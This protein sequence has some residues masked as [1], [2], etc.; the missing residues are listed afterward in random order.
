MVDRIEEHIQEEEKRVEFGKEDRTEEEDIKQ[1]SEE[2]V[3]AEDETK[4]AEAEVEDREG[5]SSVDSSDQ[6]YSPT[7]HVTSKVNDTVDESDDEVMYTPSGRPKR[8]TG[9]YTFKGKQRSSEN[10]DPEYK[11]SRQNPWKKKRGIM[12]KIHIKRGKKRGRP[13]SNPVPDASSF[14]AEAL[15]THIGGGLDLTPYYIILDTSTGD[16]DRRP[17]QCKFNDCDKRFKSKQHMREHL[18]THL[19]PYKCDGCGMGFAR[20]DYLAMHMRDTHKMSPTRADLY[21]KRK[22][23]NGRAMACRMRPSKDKRRQELQ[24]SFQI[25]KEL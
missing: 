19:K 23:A 21:N 1:E 13:R 9:N 18:F 8:R 5:S 15:S 6:D 14:R 17:Y 24:Q 25:N 4:E 16:L 7:Y 10:E 3:D 20:T 12:L 22:C 2:K 11:P